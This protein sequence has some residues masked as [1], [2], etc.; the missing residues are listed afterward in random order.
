MDSI[1][2]YKEMTSFLVKR[3]LGLKPSESEIDTVLNCKRTKKTFTAPND[4][5][6]AKESK[7]DK[8]EHNCTNADLFI[9]FKKTLVTTEKKTISNFFATLTF[10]QICFF[11]LHYDLENFEDA[12]Q[13][14]IELYDSFCLPGVKVITHPMNRLQSLPLYFITGPKEDIPFLYFVGEAIV[15]LMSYTKQKC[16]HFSKLKHIYCSQKGNPNYIIK[17]PFE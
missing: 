16:Q 3:A 17:I 9:K 2:K 8:K 10:H 11:Q 14:A 12:K 13:R 7:N 6:I 4:E 5:K 15:Q 1:E